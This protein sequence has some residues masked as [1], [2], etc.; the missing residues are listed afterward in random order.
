V[1]LQFA[2]FGFDASVSEI[3]MALLSGATLVMAKRETLISVPDLSRLL[4]S[5]KITVVTLPPS[6]LALLP[7]ANFPSLRTVISAGE[8]CSVEI[9]ER[10]SKD[11]VFINAYGPTETTIGPTFYRYNGKRDSALTVPIGKPIPNIQVF[12]VDDNFEPVPIGL[13]GEICISGVG[14]ARGYLNRPELTNEKFVDNPFY[15]NDIENHRF[16]SSPKLY[17]TGD[18]GR[19][20]EDGT[21]EFL[22]RVDY[23]VKIRG[24]RIELGEIEAVIELHHSVRQVVVMVREDVPDT[25]KLVAYLSPATGTTIKLSEI[26]R[27]IRE[28]LPE[29]MVPSAFV[30]LD[31]FPLNTNGKVDRTALPAPSTDRSEEEINYVSPTTNLEKV[32]A[33]IWEEVLGVERV[34]LNDNFFDMG[35]HSLLVAKA[36]ARLQEELSTNISLINLFRYP[37][38]SALAEFLS[39]D[40]EETVAIQESIKRAERQKTAM[41][42]QTNRMKAI[43]RSRIGDT[44][45]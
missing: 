29:Y 43:A 2:S 9:A 31:E 18:L 20:L 30:V 19:Y 34:G 13:P 16:F 24:F 42:Q 6:L 10:W 12:I 28:K 5:E 35:G 36:H 38:V 14:L 23:Q 44:D 32:I 11:R 15:I 39:G 40:S 21:I 45:N 27:F 8:S 33:S 1:V 17:R 26:R 3:F 25:K 41:R 4:E 22:G 7:E 37:T